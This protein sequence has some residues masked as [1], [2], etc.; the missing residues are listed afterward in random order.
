MSIA[1]MAVIVCLATATNETV[2]VGRVHIEPAPTPAQLEL[3]PWPREV[4]RLEGVLMLPPATT[5]SFRGVSRGDRQ[6]LLG[7][8][9]AGLMR[10]S[11]CRNAAVGTLRTSSS[12]IT[13]AAGRRYYDD[14]SPPAPLQ[15]LPDSAQKEGYRLVVTPTRV[16]LDAP[17]SL[18]AF[19]GFQTLLQLISR[20]EHDNLVIPCVAI[21]DWPAMGIRGFHM[22]ALGGRQLGGPDYGFIRRAIELASHLKMNTL[23][24]YMMGLFDIETQ[25]YISQGLSAWQWRELA[26]HARARHVQIVPIVQTLGHQKWT[27][28]W[29]GRQRRDLAADPSV[30][31]PSVYN[32]QKPRVYE[33]YFDVIDQVLDALK[34]DILHLGHDEVAAREL[35]VVAKATGKTVPELFAEDLRRYYDR[36]TPRGLRIAIWGDLLLNPDELPGS[37]YCHG[38]PFDFYKARDLVP[39]DVIIHD[40][41]YNIAGAGPRFEFPS[42]RLLMDLGFD[43]IAAPA[44]TFANCR[45]YARYA[46]RIGAMGVVSWSGG[47][48]RTGNNS[49]REHIEHALP[50]AWVAN[51]AWNP[52]AADQ[53]QPP[54]Q[55][56]AWVARRLRE[57]PKP[58]NG[59]GF[60]VDIGRYCNVGLSSEGPSRWPSTE[61][62]QDLHELPVGRHR[63][64]GTVFK[65]VDPSDNG[66]KSAVCLGGDAPELAGKPL[67]VEG[68]QI[69][70]RAGSLILLQ[71]CSAE[72]DKR[73]IWGKLGEYVIHY[74][75]GGEVRVPIVDGEN[76]RPWHAAKP[77]PMY[78]ADLAWQNGKRNCALFAFEWT[79]PYPSKTISTLDIVSNG[80]SSAPI[81]LAVTGTLPEQ[82]P[83]SAEAQARGL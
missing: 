43:V 2:D 24:V 76:V 1:L 56:T 49:F 40:W 73:T 61:S 72:Y 26:L 33:I 12:T 58:A 22:H 37:N 16:W 11:G 82:T 18:G 77:A 59:S 27:F 21:R 14:R 64:A 62:G 9:S 35:A 15:P 57:R 70:R 32:P 83:P 39:K 41:H 19:W 29:G 50:W 63:L 48:P 23:M 66:G 74:E 46:N 45:N 7:Q 54:E 44:Y 71:T 4:D 13:V 31:I 34:P 65:I 47:L 51:Y 79:N 8:L 52:Q 30:E 3:I 10:L 75:D 68:I 6:I 67:K 5:V 81:L 42:S 78:G 28:F 60:I 20:D 38:K 80:T 69:G 53:M 17:T 36:Y 55:L 25:P